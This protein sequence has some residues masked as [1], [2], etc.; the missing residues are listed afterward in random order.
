MEKAHVFGKFN[1]LVGI[2]Q[3]PESKESGAQEVAVIMLT[4]GMLHSTGPFRMYVNLARQLSVQGIASF[5]FDLSGIGESLP[6]GS[7]GSSLQRAA[8]EAKQA[9]DFLEQEYGT[10][11]FILMGLCSGAD[12]GFHTAIEDARV[13]GVILL[14]G[15][16]YP[17]FRFKVNRVLKHYLPRIFSLKFWAKRI[18]RIKKAKSDSPE[19]LQLGDDIREFPSREVAASQLQ[20][21]VDRG[22]KLN[23]VYTGGV[24]WYYNYETQFNDMFADVDFKDNV[25]T[26]FLPHLDHVAFL[27]EDRKQLID[28]LC[29]WTTANF[30]PTNQTTKQESNRTSKP[31][32]TI[33]P[34]LD[35]APG[36][37]ATSST[38][39]C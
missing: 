36:I 29:E 20:Q 8:A 3:T 30:Q 9:M 25:S 14:D 23:F 35:F 12:D 37:N 38:E 27:C 19:S 16:G 26:K 21:L 11:K 17:N 32:K 13:G 34:P 24:N 6:V 22:V 2:A 28:E 15:C 1:Q 18:A 10:K 33:M 7:S 39:T 4:A 5:R 31:T